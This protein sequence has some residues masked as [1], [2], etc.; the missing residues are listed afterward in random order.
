MLAS[1]AVYKSQTPDN[2]EMRYRICALLSE[3]SV[4]H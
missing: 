1:N 2:T 3:D 4:G